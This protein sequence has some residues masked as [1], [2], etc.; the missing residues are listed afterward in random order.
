MPTTHQV[1]MIGGR[2]ADGTV[3]PGVIGGSK[4]ANLSELDRL[5]FRVPPG[6]VLSTSL[7]QEYL[8]RGGAFGPEFPQ[9]LNSYVRRLEAITG[10][11]L[12]GRRPLLVSVRSSPPISMPGMLDTILNVG[13]TESIVRNLIRE[14]GNPAL[15]WDSY[16]RLVRTFAENVHD[17]P[18][19]AF[20]RLTATFLSEATVDRVQDLDAVTLRSLARENADLFEALIG[21][22]VPADPQTQ[23]LQ[24]VEAVC[25]S[26]NSDRAREYRR[27]NGLEEMSGTAVLI[28]A[29]VFGNGGGL[30]GSGV[31]F[32]RDPTDG[33]GQ[34]YIDVLF[35][36][37]GE[38]VVSGRQRHT[39]TLRLAKMLPDVQVELDGA[40]PRLE[41]AFRDM[42]DFE[43]TVQDGRLYFLQTRAGKRTPWA[44]L[45]IAVDLVATGVIDPSTALQRLSGIDLDALTRTRLRSG[46][47]GT[48]IATGTA[49]SLGVAT[50]AI[51]TDSAAARQMCAEQPVILVRPEISPDDIAGFEAAAGVLTSL[52][53]RTS[54]AAVV[55]RHM[56]KVCVVGCRALRIDD[57]ARRGWLGDRPFHE[58][59]L[60]TI[61]GESGHVYSG[62]VEVVIERPT[63][64]LAAVARWKAQA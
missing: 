50:G 47:D 37:Q 26:W 6:I 15:A 57:D 41:S 18:P 46:Q 40:K 29:M 7:C 31:G 20:D 54:H 22:S 4:A 10:R 49:A 61:D 11:S 62:R 14:T 43:F 64:A 23:L 3:I 25:R 33:R 63:E 13:L 48:P 30:S 16:R 56:G 12:G 58:G 60:I 45:Q 5:G 19:E 8:E 52:G 42:Q 21:A 59:D 39:D 9:L 51:A 36:A 38:D 17:A 2:P 32:T 34:L 28:Q 53:G 27:L 1:F 44:A 55:A 35:N 24:A